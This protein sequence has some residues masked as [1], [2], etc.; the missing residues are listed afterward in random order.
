MNGSIERAGR[1]IIEAARTQ[2]VDANLPEELWDYSLDS[3]VQVLNLLPQDTKDLWIQRSTTTGT[4]DS[5]EKS[6]EISA[7]TPASLNAGDNALD[8]AIEGLDLITP[9]PDEIMLRSTSQSPPEDD[10]VATNHDENANE[11]HN[12]DGDSNEQRTHRDEVNEPSRDDE[13]TSSRPCRG[14]PKPPGHYKQLSGVH[15]YNKKA[16]ITADI[17]VHDDAPKYSLDNLIATAISRVLPQ[18]YSI[19]KTF[20]QAKDNPHWPEWKK[21]CEREIQQFVTKEVY[22]LVY[23]PHDAKVL[24]GQ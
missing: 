7:M 22:E 5:P 20:K 4:S 13:T 21:A 11:H 18:G 12:S 8:T 2:L 6:P 19:P 1:T 3:T 23:P 14:D 24:P 17:Q 10:T 9:P 16:Y 15:S